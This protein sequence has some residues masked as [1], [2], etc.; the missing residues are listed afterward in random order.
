MHSVD[1]DGVGL[2]LPL[3]AEAQFVVCGII[4]LF[5]WARNCTNHADLSHLKV[6]ENAGQFLAEE[7]NLPSSIIRISDRKNNTLSESR[8]IKQAS[9][10]NCKT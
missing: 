7:P 6:E 1:D 5:G 8:P 2:S 10:R 3:L 9:L 4:A